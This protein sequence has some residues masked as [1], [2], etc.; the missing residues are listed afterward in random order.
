MQTNRLGVAALANFQIRWNWIYNLEMPNSAFQ[1]ELALFPGVDIDYQT[2]GVSNPGGLINEQIR[3]GD[4]EIPP[5]FDLFPGAEA[6]WCV[7]LPWFRA[8]EIMRIRFGSCGKGRLDIN[9]ALSSQ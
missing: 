6:P 3:T 5:G 8:L 4:S 2:P 7:P 1:I 9:G